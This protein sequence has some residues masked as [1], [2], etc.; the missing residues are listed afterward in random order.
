M[1]RLKSILACVAHFPWYPIV[2]SAYPVLA[3]LSVNFDQLDPAYA[4][5]PLLIFVSSALAL[6]LLLKALLRDWHRAAF[7]SFL[8]TLLF[9]S[10]GHVVALVEKNLGM[11]N[12]GM[13]LLPVW[14]ILFCLTLWLS[15]RPSL[16]FQKMTVY[17]NT[18]SLVLLAFPVYQIGYFLIA[19][20]VPL[21]EQSAI[22]AERLHLPQ[23]QPPP[24]VYYIIMD[25]YGRS[26]LLREAYDYDNSEFIAVLEGMGFYVAKCSQSNY[27]RT[28]QS[29][30]SSLNLD[31]LP[32]ISSVFVPDET[33]RLPLWKL[34][35]RNAVQD[36]FEQVGYRTI[37]YASGF[38][39]SELEDSDIYLAPSVMGVQPTEFEALFLRTTPAR[40]LQDFGIINL[41]NVQAVRYRERTLFVL[42][43]LEKMAQEPGPKFVFVH[44]IPPHP[45][46]VFG[47]SGKNIDPNQ[48]RDANG[49]YPA[50]GYAEGYQL[51]V[52]FISDQ[53]AQVVRTIIEKSS[54]PPV[55][56]IQGDHAPWFQP[57]E[58]SF[59]ILNAYYLPGHTDSLYS[60]I[61][62]VN[63]FRLIFNQ[64]L[65]GVFPLLDDSS[66]F[67]PIPQIYNFTLIPNACTDKMGER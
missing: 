60:A 33:D 49:N 64:Y 37:A 67:S 39:W 23:D 57:K 10:Y 65:G 24:D 8:I 20:C 32:T 51:Q 45:P 54:T 59:N 5:R 52:E 56:V 7:I 40:V 17:L 27:V 22:L 2:F 63:T 28:E 38:S 62:P 50:D 13:F 43:S 31:Y 4:F 15:T 25:S 11:P 35:K 48:F 30:A 16:P 47:P 3:L 41:N 44:L 55:I 12:P 61:S 19:E 18:F 42:H 6:F 66:Y 9:S 1:L 53:I 26:D 34:L 46:F 58:K 14:M 36:M 21:P 29:L